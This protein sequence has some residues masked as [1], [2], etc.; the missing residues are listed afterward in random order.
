MSVQAQSGL[1]SK[2]EVEESGQLKPARAPKQNHASKQTNKNQLNQWTAFSWFVGRF[3]APRNNC[4]G[5]SCQF[6]GLS[7]L[8]G[9]LGC[10][11]ITDC[12]LSCWPQFPYL[13]RWGNRTYIMGCL[14]GFFQLPHSW[15]SVN[16]GCSGLPQFLTHTLTSG[17]VVFFQS[18][19]TVHTDAS[20][21]AT[22][23]FFWIVPLCRVRLLT[24][25]LSSFTWL[26][27]IDGL[28]WPTRRH[29]G[30]WPLFMSQFLLLDCQLPGDGG[31]FTLSHWDGTCL[32]QDDKRMQE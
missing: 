11:F 15:P 14:W 2:S 31:Y 10:S 6:P 22:Q 32:A 30:C 9:S 19:Y 28:D 24:C 1:C 7:S 17:H 4:R 20:V 23:C 16:A 12:L 27:W 3:Q 29:A 5:T 18:C 26:C 8:G 25:V 13:W 21:P